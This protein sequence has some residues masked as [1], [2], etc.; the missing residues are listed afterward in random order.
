MHHENQRCTKP[1][2]LKGYLISYFVNK[3]RSI[4]T[5]KQQLQ[6]RSIF[7]ANPTNDQLYNF[8]IDVTSRNSKLSNVSPL[9]ATIAKS[10]YE[11][12]AESVVDNISEIDDFRLLLSGITERDSFR[13]DNP[14]IKSDFYRIG[15]KRYFPHIAPSPMFILNDGRRHL[16]LRKRK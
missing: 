12:L 4:S 8:A 16:I 14:F 15:E 7:T 10:K 11:L 6:S 2:L 1:R 3:L 5:A 13:I 9:A